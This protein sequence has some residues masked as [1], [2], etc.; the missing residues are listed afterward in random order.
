M[1]DKTE[2]PSFL[3]VTYGNVAGLQKEKEN[4]NKI[5]VLHILVR[6]KC[7]WIYQNC[8]TIYLCPPECLWEV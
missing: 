3:H 4:V 5:V 6:R 8:R 1:H 7:L 2:Y